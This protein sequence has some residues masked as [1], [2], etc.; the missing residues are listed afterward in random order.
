MELNLLAKLVVL[1]ALLTSTALADCYTSGN[2]RCDIGDDHAIAKVFKTLCAPMA[3]DFPID[4]TIESCADY[5]NYRVEAGIHIL[6]TE[7]SS[8]SPHAFLYEDVKNDCTD[9]G[10]VMN[11][12]AYRGSEFH[13]Y[14][15][16]YGG[17]G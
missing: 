5:Q 13:Q 11:E 4:Y 14:S 6:G 15:Y 10:G 2:A 7:N 12:S 1:L 3:G 17:H 9:H 8:F 16:I